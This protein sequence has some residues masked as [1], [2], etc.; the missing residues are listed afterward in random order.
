MARGADGRYV[1]GLDL[2]LDDKVSA[3]MRRILGLFP[4]LEKA[5]TRANKAFKFAAN[6]KQSADG[7]KGFAD[8]M[9]SAVGAPIKKMMEFEDIMAKV[10]ANTFNG[11]V[12]A[13]THTEFK[14]LQETA[15]KLG[16]DT[17]FSGVEAAEGLDILATAG[18][19]AKGQIAALPGILDLAAASNQSIAEAAEIATS[20]MSQFGLKAGEM[21]TIGDVIAKTAQSSK[22]G[23]L[24]IGEALKY[25]GV[26][27]KNAGVSLEETTA[28][29]GALGDAGVKGSAAGTAL[30][31]VFSSLQAPNKKGKSALEFLGVN[32]KDKNGNMRPV[33]DI[34]KQMDAAMDRKF[35]K[36]KNGNRRA[37]LLKG[38]FD[39][40]NAASASL[41]IAKAGTGE[42]K[43]KI[44]TNLGASGTAAKVAAD[45]SNSTAGSA[46]E[47]SSA[48][49]ELQLT[50]GEILIP[51]VRDFVNS[52]KGALE[53]VTGWAKENPGWAKG[54]TYVAGVLGV[55][56][57]GVWGTVTAVG[58][59]AT[60]WGALMTV[61]G[62]VGK[63]ALFLDKVM[64]VLKLGMLTNPI[65]LIIIAIATAA[66][67]IYEYWE[68][69]SKFFSDLWGGIKDVFAGV[70][71]WI[72]GKIEW[73]AD[74]IAWLGE[75][76]LGLRA[77]IDFSEVD[78]G[79][80]DQ[81]NK[82]S[83]ADLQVLAKDGKGKVGDAARAKVKMQEFEKQAP[84]LIAESKAAA[85]GVMSSILP[86]GGAAANGRPTTTRSSA[87][88]A[89]NEAVM[90]ASGGGS[91]P[92]MPSIAGG[93]PVMPSMS[94][95]WKGELTIKINA[96]GQVSGSHLKA[97]GAP[98][99]AVRVNTGGQV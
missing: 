87:E 5:G 76:L 54:L 81:V 91:L 62:L 90:A 78:K 73:V 86:P 36:D 33:N 43:N 93:A 65:T 83:Q 84:A 18:F 82:L 59:A 14:Q 19:D 28:M 92:V 48:F 17:K 12:T 13:Q 44:N 27:A 34:L 42:L 4:G 97:A 80:A 22:T 52:I 26:S 2:V 30:R 74:K 53:A 85:A 72:V 32:T 51:T 38:L 64:K 67:L 7:I 6:L 23:L 88:E 47:L 63:A 98:G 40:A 99:F 20:A 10:R 89:S 29:L 8:G 66:L 75:N 21:G 11:E 25:A 61:W 77:G 56:A 24:D 68:P 70:W 16:A 95:S 1:A 96:E 50:L 69:I 94:G 60:A 45:M 9:T 58:A 35:G 39:E 15:R 31:S 79:I 37:T 71:E 55:V 3:G 49:E 57:L 46:R 41:L